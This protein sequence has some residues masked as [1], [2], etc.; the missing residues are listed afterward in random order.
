MLFGLILTLALSSS[1]RPQTPAPLTITGRVMSGTPAHP[2]ANAVVGVG[3]ASTLTDADGRFSLVVA[4]P[5][6]PATTVRMVVTCPG[7]LD[8]VIDVAPGAAELEVALQP[9]AQVR[10]QILVSAPASDQPVPPPT[11]VVA[12]A[13]VTSV[14]GALDNVFRVLQTMPGVS[15][16]DDF[17]SRLSVRGGGPDENLT[18]MDGVEI[19]NPYRL[20]GLTSAFN[21][22]T[23]DRF[24]LTAG[25]FSAKYGDRLSSILVVDNRRGTSDRA[26]AGSA[27]LSITDANVVL[28]GR[29]PKGA[30]GSWLLTGRRTYYDLVAE[31]V[32]DQDLPSFG[33]LQTKIAWSLPRGRELTIFG[34]RS[35]ESTDAEFTDSSM[36]ATFGLADRSSNDI[37]SVSLASP[38]GTRGTSR[39]VAS[40]YRFG[41]ALDVDGSARDET[42]RFNVPGDEAFGRASIVFTRDVTVDDASLRQDVSMR[43]ADRHTLDTGAEVHVLRTT[44]GWTIAGDR[45]AD[46]ANGSSAL[47]GSGLPDLLDSSADSVRAGA[48]IEDEVRVGSRARVAGGL[49]VDWNGISK[50]TIASPRLRF[51]FEM[52]PRTTLRAATGVYTQSPGYE[53]LLQSDYFVDLTH[54]SDLD[55]RSARSRHLVVGVEHQ[56]SPAVTVKTEAYYKAFDRLLVGR[57]ETP[58]ETAARVAQYAFPAD[59]AW[60]VPASPQIT[61]MPSSSG[62]GDAYGFDVYLQKRATSRSDRVTGWVSYTWGRAFIESYGRRYPFDYDRRHALSV[63]STIRLSR[64]FDLGATLRVASG[65]PENAPIGV[66]VASVLAPGA[67]DGEPGSLIPARSKDGLLGWTI[68]RGGVDQLNNARLP[69]YARLDLRLTYTSPRASHWQLYVEAINALNHENA[70]TLRAALQYDPTSDRPSIWLSRDQGLSLLPTFGLRLKF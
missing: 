49:R 29:L 59:L 55:I 44:W 37:V 20:F 50:E 32:T 19:H 42:R 5:V 4:R 10:E 47:G 22:E 57:L 18:V 56:M 17:G 11:L 9:S 40:W 70:G 63:V 53:K 48:W 54:A 41:D 24:E 26:L 52:G 36:D 67:T 38:L 8:A 15:A 25:G 30:N 14:A 21:P 64:R 68:D 58:E 46:E 60:S 3:T 28:E 66:R 62:V 7:F 12:P 13:E 45:N 69:A 23:I 6:P 16:T 31:R 65:F 61:S 43:V 1:V 35:R 2:I 27:S 39:T 51:Q 34:L 33:D